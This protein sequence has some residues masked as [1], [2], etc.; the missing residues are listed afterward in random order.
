MP[1]RADIGDFLD[2]FEL[3]QQ[4]SLPTKAYVLFPSL[5]KPSQ[6][7]CLVLDFGAASP[8]QSDLISL[9][10][11]L[12]DTSALRVLEEWRVK[13]RAVLVAVEAR[14]DAE[15]LK[16]PYALDPVA[17]RENI[18]EALVMTALEGSEWRRLCSSV[19]DQYSIDQNAVQLEVELRKNE[20][21]KDENGP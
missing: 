8:A 19:A 16:K 10:R 3:A 18:F 17:V 9:I 7:S 15:D 21:S 5:H 6:K 14:V 12:I 4:Y 1:V 11:F 20:L 13:D 2:Q